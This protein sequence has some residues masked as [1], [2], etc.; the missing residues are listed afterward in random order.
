[1]SIYP[2]NIEYAILIYTNC[3][4][5]ELD[6]LLQLTQSQLKNV[7][8]FKIKI[9]QVRNMQKQIIEL[10]TDRNYWKNK[11]KSQSQELTKLYVQNSVI[12]DTCIHKFNKNFLDQLDSDKNENLNFIVTSKKPI[13]ITESNEV[14]THLKS[15]P[16][17]INIPYPYCGWSLDSIK[18]CIKPNIW[19][20]KLFNLQ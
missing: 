9:D 17:P 6:N 8:K 13:L 2:I 15:V 5:I 16:P 14:Y 1:M 20:S 7:M 12:D 11:A 10:T 18:F 3:K 19:I 4:F